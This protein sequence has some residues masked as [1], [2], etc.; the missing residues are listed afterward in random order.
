LNQLHEDTKAQIQI[1]A[2]EAKKASDASLEMSRKAVL[3]PVAGECARLLHQAKLESTQILGA[4]REEVT[5]TALARI[6]R[7]LIELRNEPDYARILQRLTKEAIAALGEDEANPES[8]TSPNPPEIEVDLRDEP[9]LRDILR[10]MELDLTVMSTLT[11][12]GGVIVRSGD[13]RIMA[14]NTFE[15][16]LER[17]TPYLRH[18]LV[19]FFMSE[20]DG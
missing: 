20:P 13:G 19:H 10:E 17:V 7:H 2:D 1:I 11:S 12:W 15:S 6:R 4:A 5:S 18:K 3:G 16:R 9:V 14:T 8:A